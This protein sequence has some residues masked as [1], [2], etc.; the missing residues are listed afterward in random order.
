MTNYII[1]TQTDR[2][3]LILAAA[4]LKKAQEVAEAKAAADVRLPVFKP[5][6]MAK[7]ALKAYYRFIRDTKVGALI[8]AHFL[9]N[10]PSFYMPQRGRSITINF[11]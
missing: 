7:F 9:L 1:K 8:V 3:Q 5:L 2:R 4:V 6:N 10:Q 11:Y